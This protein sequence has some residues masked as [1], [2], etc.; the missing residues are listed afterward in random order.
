M[1]ETIVIRYNHMKIAI[2]TSGILPVPA[3]QGGAV[4]NLID[5]YLEYN[6]KQKLHEITIY[7][8]YHP[9]VRHRPERKS[10]INHYYYINVNSLWG[11][12]KRRLYLYHY[13]LTDN[14]YYNHYIEYY[15][16]EAYKHIRK[17]DYDII[18]MEN[19]P[20]YALKLK[21]K[22]IKARLIC[23]L[24]NDLININTLY[25]QQIYDSL[26]RIITVSNYISNCVK[27]I[28]PNDKKCITVYN[29]INLH[30]F[31]PT[32]TPTINRKDIGIEEEDFVLIFSGRINKE[33]GI[34]EL[35]K[36]MYQL[37][38]YQRIKL[39]VIGS[40][41][42][43]DDLNENAFIKEIKAIAEPLRKRIIFTGF[44]PYERI[45]EYIKISNVAVIPS[46]WNDP[47]PTTVL[48]AQAIGLPIIATK[49][50][51]IPEEVTK[52]NAI[53]LETDDCF[54]DSL[55]KSIIH[56]YNHPDICETMH[57]N[58]ISHSLLYNKE[59][60]AKDFFKAIIS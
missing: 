22:G 39:I 53:L 14:K 2:L 48:E 40:S 41:F 25:A 30:D 6:D 1:E 42:F 28:D 11:R 44:V 33:K 12:I 24:H 21:K 59:R 36:S 46:I 13:K 57:Q 54:I 38:D 58:S 8:I 60:F 34:R 23:H 18:I 20:A 35:I 56:L 16:K 51:G 15:F 19:R 7:S 55:A 10:S 5:F 52:R 43:G 29:G 9:L 49:N 17:Q 32:I 47:F 4:E 26:S 3:V 50:G 31:S 27:T 37:N 45:P